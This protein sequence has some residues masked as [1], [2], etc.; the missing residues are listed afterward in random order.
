VRGIDAVAA[1]GSKDVTGFVA[2]NPIV[3]HQR[4]SSIGACTHKTAIP[5]QSIAPLT[6]R[7]THVWRA[8]DSRPSLEERIKAPPID[9]VEKQ[10]PIGTSE[11]EKHWKA[12]L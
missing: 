1:S 8:R 2:V 12:Y 9:C 3:E 11:W 6:K 5:N 4:G 10:E 7:G